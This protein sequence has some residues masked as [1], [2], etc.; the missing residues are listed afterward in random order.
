[1]DSAL[2][3]AANTSVTIWHAFFCM[4]CS[5]SASLI[6]S[7]FGSNGRKQKKF[8]FFAY[9][10]DYIILYIIEFIRLGPA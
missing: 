3:H 2:V 1:M 8:V 10:Y 9:L 6:G 7:A 4:P 5:T